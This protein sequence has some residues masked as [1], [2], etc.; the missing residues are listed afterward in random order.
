[1]LEEAWHHPS[2]E[3]KQIP[4]EYLLKGKRIIKYYSIIN[5][6]NI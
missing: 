5:L 4:I 3:Y 6:Y 2:K 1:M